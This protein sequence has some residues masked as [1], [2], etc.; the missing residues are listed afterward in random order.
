M[1]LVHLLALALDYHPDKRA[2]PSQPRQ[3]EQLKLL[4]GAPLQASCCGC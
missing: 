3:K 4:A 2:L 1:Q